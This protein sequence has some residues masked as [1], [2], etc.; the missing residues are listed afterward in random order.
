MMM[1][2]AAMEAPANG[3]VPKGAIMIVSTTPIRTVAV[4]ATMIG[5]DS[6]ISRRVSRQKRGQGGVGTAC[7]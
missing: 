3:T 5:V 7:P 2:D 4:N 1:T 6:E